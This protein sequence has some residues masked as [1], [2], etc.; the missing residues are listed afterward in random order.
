[1]VIPVGT[2]EANEV[3]GL[4]SPVV[5]DHQFSVEG[6][7]GAGGTPS[8]V[9]ADE[10]GRIASEVAVGGPVVLELASLRRKRSQSFSY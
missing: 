8:A 4:S 2:E 5:L 6:A 9:P 7:F 10:D 3:M 1:M